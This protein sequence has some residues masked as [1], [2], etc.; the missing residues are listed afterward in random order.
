MPVDCGEMP[1]ASCAIST[2]EFTA[3][4]APPLI[5]DFHALVRLLALP[6]YGCNV[7]YCPIFKFIS[8]LRTFAVY[9][10]RLRIAWGDPTVLCT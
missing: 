8:V 1:A 6:F 9:A 10:A 2:H 3:F 5:I 4:K 7:V